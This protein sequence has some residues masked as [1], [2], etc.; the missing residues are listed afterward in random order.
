MSRSPPPNLAPF[1]DN[2]SSVSKSGQKLKLKMMNA[3]KTGP[4]GISLELT[5]LKSLSAQV[6]QT[7]KIG[8]T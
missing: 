8:E 4:A 3:T 5:D 1:G 7:S 2:E 6:L